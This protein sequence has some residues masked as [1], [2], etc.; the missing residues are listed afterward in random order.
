MKAINLTKAASYLYHN[1]YRNKLRFKLY[2]L[3]KGKHPQDDITAVLS[4][5]I[6]EAVAMVSDE[7][8]RLNKTKKRRKR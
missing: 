7:E 3:T 5:E 1:D 2:E 8:K 4:D 6:L